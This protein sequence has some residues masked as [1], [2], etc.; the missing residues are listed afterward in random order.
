M[1][2][3]RLF[4][5]MV[6][7]GCALGVAPAVASASEVQQAA[8]GNWAGYVV[9]DSSGKDFK[10]VSASWTQPT[11]N[12][13]NAGEYAAFWVGLGGSGQSG[14]LEQAG[15]EAECTSD[16]SPRYF[17]WY[18]LVPSMPVTLG[19]TVKPGDHIYTRVVVAG[20]HVGI[21]VADQTTGRTATRSLTMR[22][23]D[24]SSAEWIA[25]APSS[26]QQGVTNCQE[27]P[28]ADF[29]TVKFKNAYA[30][31]TAGH[32]G[33]VSD[34]QWSPVAVTL[35]GGA[36]SQGFGG[37][38][39]TSS[40]SSAGATP[41]SLTTDGASFT[42]AYAAD[43]SGGGGYAGY[44]GGGDAGG[45]GGGYPGYGGGGYPGYGGGYPGSYGGGGYGY[46]GGGYGYYG[47]AYSGSGYSGSGY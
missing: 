3:K 42:V 41:S 45:Y 19:L 37:A 44:G 31:D 33:A 11:A 36:T 13:T 16:G 15:T 47:S 43:G 32:T 34:S 46:Y 7:A 27:L 8:S 14:K 5:T 39:F 29:G 25:E 40:D 35:D 17:A 12:C 9:K 18:E 1:K 2:A 24:T 20:D 22:G 26:C 4:A 38:E 6:A 30:T 21:S 28:L 10:S 23:P